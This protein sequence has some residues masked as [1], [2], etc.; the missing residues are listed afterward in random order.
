MTLMQQIYADFSD[1]SRSRFRFIV[2]S[3]IRNPAGLV[4]ETPPDHGSG[5]ARFDK[6]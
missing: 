4:L 2:S 1:F 3:R 5:S 6:S